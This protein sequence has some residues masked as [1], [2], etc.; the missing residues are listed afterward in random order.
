[1]SDDLT[2]V[3]KEQETPLMREPAT[4]PLVPRW[5]KW[6][7]YLLLGSLAVVGLGFLTRSLAVQANLTD[8][9]ATIR[10]NL[11]RN[12]PLDSPE[13]Q[14]AIV[15]L[16]GH[17]RYSFLYCNQEILQNEED[18]PRMVRAMAL[19][20][21]IRWGKISRRRDVIST[22]LQ[23]MDEEGRL[24]REFVLSSEIT[25]VLSRMA[26]ERIANPELSY[27]E[28]RITDV[29]QWLA[30]GATTR[31]KGP[32]KDRLRA[33]QEQLQ[34][35]YYVTEEAAALKALIESWNQS[36]EPLERKA[37][38]HFGL[39]L[40]QERTALPSEVARHCG[41]EADRLEDL[42]RRGMVRLADASH[43]MLG[44]VVQRGMFLDHPHINQ[45]LKLLRHRYEGIRKFVRKGVWIL[46]HDKYTVMFLSDFLDKVNIN[47]VMAVETERLT[48][49]EHERVMRRE[50]NRRRRAALELLTRI[51]L[52]YLRNPDPYLPRVEDPDRYLRQHVTHVMEEL[53][54]D[55]LLGDRIQQSLA[56]LRQADRNRTTGP[57]L[58]AEA[59]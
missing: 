1:M 56:E 20:K 53:A 14:Q 37:A 13:A 59:E 27:A 46:R 16:G 8:A 44:K 26:E 48:K 7:F 25:E 51:V 30:R 43:R 40:Q 22:I 24:D 47:P 49:E 54:D 50:N 41:E 35:K 38:E 55:R 18:D 57:R 2:E 3:E 11:Q 17:P 36:S 4:G 29:I 39:M 31:P 9:L 33:L 21:A 52:D 42:Y 19:R 58:F 6:T 12:L 15:V 10:G 5:F 23:N 28:K 45:Y 32:E 34:K